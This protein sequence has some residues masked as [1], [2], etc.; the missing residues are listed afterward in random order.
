MDQQEMLN[1]LAQ[2]IQ[3]MQ[4]KARAIAQQRDRSMPLKR[5][6]HAKGIGVRAR[7]KV[8][9]DIP[10]RLQIGLFQPNAEYEALVRFSNA[11]GE[12]LGDLA[13]DQRGC[14][15]RVKTAQG[16]ALSPG[17]YSNIQDF[18]MTNTPISFA[19][20]P[21]QF[22][23]VGEILLEG[24]A[25][26]PGKLIQKYGWKEARRILG[27]FLEPLISFKPLQMNQYWSRTSYK[28][29]ET[30]VRY[31][32]RPSAGS[33]TLSSFQQFLGVVRSI[34]TGV[35]QKE[36]YLREKLLEELQEHDVHFDFCVQQFVD[37]QKTPIEDAYI[38]W[39]ESDSPPICLATLTIPRQNPDTQLQTEM[40][41][42][43]FNPWH[44]RDF[45]PL[46]LINLARKKV[47]DASARNR[48]SSLQPYQ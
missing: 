15:I 23:E 9:A 43:A 17:E 27:V 13:K 16:E 19:R 42:V 28:F 29:G 34:L 12:V 30:S 46:G 38:E 14:A 8:N 45:T 6:F 1:D 24:T 35:P 48:G 10:Q 33:K 47:Y 32:I 3:Q 22:I 20:N 11:R 41:Q 5:G 7:F 44:T 18:L 2:R 37:E 25:K 31:L 36:N 21:L 39:K 40:E 26:V 4:A